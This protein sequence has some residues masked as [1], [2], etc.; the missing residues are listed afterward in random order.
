MS[1]M[2]LYTKISLAKWKMVQRSQ[3]WS[4]KPVIKFEVMVLILVTRVFIHVSL[5]LWKP[6]RK[7][8]FQLT[9]IN[10]LHTS[11]KKLLIKILHFQLNTILCFQNNDV[12]CNFRIV[13][14]DYCMGIHLW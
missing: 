14:G 2:K 3:V 13:N 1:S 8:T 9:T 10:Y 7:I 12:F 5:P 6:S 4:S 11:L